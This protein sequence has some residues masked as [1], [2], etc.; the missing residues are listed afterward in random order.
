MEQKNKEFIVKM[1]DISGNIN[2]V[3][4]YGTSKESIISTIND[5]LNE[6]RNTVR[7]IHIAEDIFLNLNNI[8]SIKVVD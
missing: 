5:K 3:T 4:M 8:V 7:F 2:S 1:T 6:L